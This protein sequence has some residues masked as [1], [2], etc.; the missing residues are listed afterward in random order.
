MINRFFSAV[1]AAALTFSLVSALS[2]PVS[3]A[4]LYAARHTPGYRAA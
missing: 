2:T 4:E 3:A 1:A